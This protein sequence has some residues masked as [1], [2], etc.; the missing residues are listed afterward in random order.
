MKKLFIYIIVLLVGAGVF[1]L[2][3]GYTKKYQPIS[4]YQVYL[5]NEK[6]GVI[7]SKEELEKYVDSQGEL[8]KKQ[9]S[10][11][12]VKTERIDTVRKIM[13]KVIK[14]KSSFYDTYSKMLSIESIYDKLSNYVDNEGNFK[15]DNYQNVNTIFNMIS[16]KYK[17]NVN[18]LDNRIE[19]YNKLKTSIDSS[20][21]VLN[22]SIVNALY[23]RKDNLN[24]TSSEYSFLEDYVKNNYN[25]IGYS[26]YK[27]MKLYIKE[28]EIYK[29][30]SNIF[31][32]IGINVKKITT[33]KKDTESVKKV[34]ERIISKKPCTIEGYRFKIK[35]STGGTL[36]Q[37]TILGA[38]ALSD[39]KNIT[40]I[41]TKD[42]IIYVTNPKIF[43]QAIDE[44]TSVF[45]GSE[46]YEKYKNNKQKDIKNT[47][48]KINNV[49]LKEAISFKQINISVK[50]RIFS[51]SA[52]L[53]SYLLYGDN[54]KTKTVYASS[55]DS[56]T[57]LAYKNGITIEEFFLSNPSFTSINN[58]FYENQPITITKL[59]PKISLVVEESQVIDK[60]I[61]YKKVEKYDNMMNQGDEFVE[62][63]GKKGLMRVFQNVQKVNGSIASVVPVSKETIRNAQDEVIKVG[64]K[65]IPHVGSTGSWG[66][67]TNSGY[68]LSS[69]FGWRSYPF[70]PGQR[71]FHAG[72]DI[73]GTGYGSPIYASN[74][75]TIEVMKRDRWNY[76]THIIINHNNGYWT[77]YGHMSGFAKGLK[78]GSTV[79]RG[80]VIGYMGHTGA[81]TGTHLH[82]EIRVGENRYSN[83][84]D[85]L[86]YLKK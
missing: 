76:G 44:V 11:Y 28:N 23:E 22:I 68:T 27:Y 52:D 75:G 35:K 60:S 46:E 69:Y 16:D 21:R 36:T 33:Y 74:N 5:D 10:D 29:H 25:D 48:S 20:I 62:Q 70:N 80:Q 77:T 82:F 13:K 41:S 57:S 45:V 84:V 78:Q 26:K 47:G 31:E 50:E 42:I 61:D 86:P 65:V 43:N 63:K 56:I 1:L 39:F 14:R 34:Y 59:N 7:N 9:V 58:I 4:V 49:Y 72:L 55:K 53:A 32:P 66:W 24:L 2:Q 19:N 6:I 83:V 12:S 15:E 54:L 30:T 85:P 81:A 71:E 38:L 37:N 40:S 17:N 73:A 67:P 18:L 79:T 8:I 64:T 51:D 3:F